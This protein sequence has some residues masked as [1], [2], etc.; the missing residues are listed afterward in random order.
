MLEALPTRDK[1]VKVMEQQYNLQCV[2]PKQKKVI[3]QSIN[4]PIEIPVNPLLGCISLLEDQNLMQDINLIF[5][6]SH[7][8]LIIEP[9]SG[10]YS[11]V[12]TGLAYH[13][14]Q[15]GIKHFGNAIQVPLI[16]FINTLQFIEHVNIFKH[17]SCS[18]WVF[19]NSVFGT[20]AKLGA[21]LVL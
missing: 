18:L 17:P 8:P 14:F 15:K 3:L 12:N 4:L 20:G 9:Y 16:F 19:S 21:I 2:A 1:V 6:D 5:P 13:S 11:E 10:K 7:D